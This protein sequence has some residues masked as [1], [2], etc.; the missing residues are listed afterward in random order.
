MSPHKIILDA[1]VMVAA[2]TMREIGHA[3]AKAFMEAC[4]AHSLPILIPAIALAE[5]SGALSRTGR[6]VQKTRRFLAVYRSQADFA[7]APVEVALG[8]DAAAIALLQHIKGCD[9]IYLA[10]ARE[11]G[12]PLVTLDREQR[13]RAPEDVEVLTPEEALAAWFPA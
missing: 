11:L 4:T 9:A 1:S 8:E 12:L 13:E 6:S 3:P 5:F 10:V 2:V 7:V